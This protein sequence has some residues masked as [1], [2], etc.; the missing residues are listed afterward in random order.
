MRSISS[1]A[2]LVALTA[3]VGCQDVVI[4]DPGDPA[5]FLDGKDLLLCPGDDAHEPNDVP[6]SAPTL[7]GTAT[8]IRCGDNDD[9]F[10]FDIPRAGCT[11]TGAL[12]FDAASG[13]LQLSVLDA[14]GIEVGQSLGAGDSQGLN[15]EA[16]EA[17][18]YYARVFGPGAATTYDLDLNIDCPT[19]VEL[20]CPADDPAEPNN[21]AA[22]ATP[23]NGSAE[24]IVCADNE[25]HYSVQI[26]EV[27]CE[28][29]VGLFFSNDDGDLDLQVLG[30]DGGVLAS[31]SSTDDD[32]SVTATTSATGLHTIRVHGFQGAEAQYLVSV[33]AR[34]GGEIVPDTPP[35]I[36]NPADAL[37]P[38]DDAL[39]PNDSSSE[40]TVLDD[41]TAEGV[42]CSGDAD[43][44]DTFVNEGCVLVADLT[45][46]DELGDLDLEVTG[47]SGDVEDRSVG[48]ADNERVVETAEGTGLQVLKVYGF[49]STQNTYSIATQTLCRADFNCT[50]DDP[51]EQ[52]SAWT[53]DPTDRASGIVCGS[54]DRDNYEVRVS[55]RCAAR[56]AIDFTHADG[57]IDINVK[58]GESTVARGTSVTDDETVFFAAETTATYGLELR[59]FSSDNDYTVD[60]DTRCYDDLDCSD[61]DV[62][63]PNKSMNEAR[64]I[65]GNGYAVGIACNSGGSTAD[66]FEYS[67]TSG[68]AFQASLDNTGITAGGDL[69]LKVFNAGGTKVAESLTGNTVESV[70][71]TTASSGKFKVKVEG[72]QGG[73]NKYELN[74]SC[75]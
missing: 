1:I 38:A 28:L 13:A 12:T 53:L 48:T 65:S 59:R 26:A 62:Y 21:D 58:Q 55:S 34:C 69:D 60:V 11:A 4:L 37:C 36:E 44:F 40:A 15:F 52:D 45:F 74:V 33:D 72:F 39:E 41:A 9:Y 7:T 66:W 51:Y 16:P 35:S 30:P 24:G 54:D 57:D 25:D 63:A 42:I 31:G 20:T 49:G 75:E 73:S 43:Y 32:E 50:D 29:G 22:S 17:G 19:N 18:R 68:C 14:R 46:S 56:A 5:D 67:V 70:S 23:I 61:D 6:A 10:A 27:G 8:G 2:L 71:F 64:D 3:L 47:T